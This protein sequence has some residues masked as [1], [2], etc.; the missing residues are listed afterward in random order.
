MISAAGPGDSPIAEGDR[1]QTRQLPAL[2][3]ARIL[4]AASEVYPL[5][6]TGGL[7]DVAGSL[8]PALQE[9]GYDIRILMPAYGD[10][11]D[12]IKAVSCFRAE[13]R[14]D[15]TGENVRLLETVLP[16]HELIVY[17]IDVPQRFNRTGNPYH[18]A[19][20]VEWSDNAERFGLFGRVIERIG[21]GEAGLDW[22]PDL[23]H[24]NDWHTGLGPALL[25]QHADRP[26]TVFTIH[27]LMYQGNFPY[28]ALAVLGLPERFWS[29]ETLEF[30]G[31]LSFI[32]GGLVFADRLVAVSP[33]YAREITTPEFGCGLDG[34]L[35]QRAGAL[36]GILNGVDYSNWDPRYD[37]HI[38]RN[39]WMDD[40]DHKRD[41]KM[42][43]QETLGLE[44]D[45][46]AAVL[47]YIGRLTHQKGIDLL[48]D[49][50]DDLLADMNTHQLVILGSG[51][52]GYVSALQA[53]AA[54]WPRR[55]AVWTGFDETLAHV[56]QAGADMLLMPSRFEPCG[57]TQLYALRYGTV[58]VARATGGLADTIT[59]ATRTNLSDRTATGFLFRQP[60][61][62]MLLNVLRRAL[63]VYMSDPG[64][65]S[66]IMLRGMQC[67]FN[68]RKSAGHYDKLYHNI[69][70]VSV[71][72]AG[73]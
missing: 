13:F 48:I 45:R 44:V 65:W 28:E 49:I 12:A 21:R 31:R 24:C 66:R 35:R 43:L 10:V 59:D 22:Q 68:W 15:V 54:K 57:L 19:G 5:I 17:L 39:Y 56:I 8:P 42:V 71:R 53:A 64:C 27:N 18:D 73:K 38:H 1:L 61:P 70:P 50:L 16:G 41:N 34:L 33:G 51:D 25:A 67:N 69:L 7:A 23:I 36:S 3:R 62:R 72:S 14:I 37:R 4:F 26:A 20:M 9:L 55:M 32:K 52:A 63:S 47:A 60:G 2:P 46:G 29:P 11:L 40:L 30:H 58:P 6:Q